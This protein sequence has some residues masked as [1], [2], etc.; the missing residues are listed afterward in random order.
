MQWCIGFIHCYC[1]Q[2]NCSCLSMVSGRKQCGLQQSCVHDH[3][4]RMDKTVSCSVTATPMSRCK[5]CNSR[6]RHKS[7]Q[8]DKR[9]GFSLSNVLWKRSSAIFNS[10]YWTYR[11]TGFI[12]RDNQFTRIHNKFH[13]GRSC[14][15]ETIHHQNGHTT[16][17][18]L[19]ST[20]QNRLCQLWLDLLNILQHRVRWIHIF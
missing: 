5:Q 1:K 19:N 14:R 2:W 15:F 16:S 3:R 8:Y 13:S 6:Y 20:F 9:T 11:I 10:R 7:E 17:S 4:W 18:T 12:S